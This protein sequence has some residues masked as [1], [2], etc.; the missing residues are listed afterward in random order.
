M[1]YKSIYSVLGLP[2]LL[3]ISSCS[4]DFIIFCLLVALSRQQNLVFLSYRYWAT[5]IA[6]KDIWP[7]PLIT[8]GSSYFSQFSSNSEQSQSPS[9]CLLDNCSFPDAK[10]QLKE[11]PWPMSFA[12]VSCRFYLIPLK[13]AASICVR[14]LFP[15]PCPIPLRWHSL[16]NVGQTPLPFS[17]MR[18]KA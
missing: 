10:K 2:K 15:P 6:T 13:K 1:M 5:C 14:H 3:F 12:P 18:P 9:F 17:V 8:N 7:V 16:Y 11:Y 4:Q